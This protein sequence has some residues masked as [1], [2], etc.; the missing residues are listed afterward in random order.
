MLREMF[1][2]GESRIA[3]DG[4]LV[5]IELLLLFCAFDWRGIKECKRGLEVDDTLPCVIVSI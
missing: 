2:A 5:D 4:S 1:E 3:E